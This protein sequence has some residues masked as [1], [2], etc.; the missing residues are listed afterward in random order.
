M[1]WLIRFIYK[2]F[3]IVWILMDLYHKNLKDLEGLYR[4]IRFK[5]TRWIFRNT[6]KITRDGEKSNKNKEVWIKKRSKTNTIFLI[7]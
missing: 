3:K 7:V 4:F 5:S 2:T 1:L 6:F